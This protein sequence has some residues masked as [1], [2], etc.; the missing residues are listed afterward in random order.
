MAYQVFSPFSFRTCYLCLTTVYNKV[1]SSVRHDYHLSC[2][3]A[4]L[5]HLYPNQYI[6]DDKTGLNFRFP[7]FLTT[8]HMAFST[9]G[10]RVLARYTHLLDGLANV[11]VTPER[12][13]RNILPIGALFSASLV[14]SNAAYLTLSVSY[15]QMLK[16][17][18]PVAVLF[19]SFAFGLKQ[20]SG[21]LIAIVTMISFGVATASY[22][23]A[24]FVLSGFIAQVLAI[25]FE[26]SRL[27]MVQVLLQ[28]LKMDPLVSL[29]Y[30]A[31]VCAAINFGLLI[32]SEGLQPFLQLYRL[33]P[34]VL[35]T[36]A[37]VAFG[38]NITAVFLSELSDVLRLQCHLL[39]FSS[40][41]VSR[42]GF[43]SGPDSVGCDQRHSLDRRQRYHVRITDHHD[44]GLWLCSGPLWPGPLQVEGLNVPVGTHFSLQL[45][46]S[47][48]HSTGI[49]VSRHHV[50]RLC[51]GSYPSKGGRTSIQ[52]P[53]TDHYAS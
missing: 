43:V 9:V 52:N 2:H 14:T 21:T 13:Y 25:A 46:G 27:V 38:L 45:C 39:T 7:V 26:S 19:I 15:I 18:M 8:F 31:P 3:L 24:E 1:C 28:G 16:A 53:Y 37:G 29:Y 40:P 10:T 51:L 42:S 47:Q 11:D 34:F 32:V 36:N 50:A 20:P 44:P 41:L 5:S 17:F 35:L 22:G 12:W 48:I 33:G 6:L 23:E 4:D 30:F 49:C